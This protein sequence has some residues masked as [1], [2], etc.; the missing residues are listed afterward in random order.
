MKKKD[1]VASRPLLYH[2]SGH[3]NQLI[4]FFA[5][6][7]RHS[8]KQA[9]DPA[10][11]SVAPLSHAT[12]IFED[13]FSVVNAIFNMGAIEGPRKI[14]GEG[15]ICKHRQTL[16]LP[17][18]DANSLHIWHW[19]TLFKEVGETLQALCNQKCL[20]MFAP[21]Y[22]SLVIVGEGGVIVLKIPMH[23]Y[24]QNAVWNDSKTTQKYIQEPHSQ[25]KAFVL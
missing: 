12:D 7:K 14:N 3:N 2:I 16:I 5:C 4:V 24:V 6:G 18:K 17:H 22:M 21:L 25:S 8:S 11:I 9:K 23:F 15:V 19:Q 20:S 1:T 13:Y 10:S